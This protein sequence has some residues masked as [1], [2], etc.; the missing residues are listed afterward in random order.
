[1]YKMR[2]MRKDLSCGIIK[3][4]DIGLPEMDVR[5]SGRCIECGHCALFCPESANCLSFLKNDEMVA[6]DDLDMPTASE[7]IEFYKVQEKHK[8]VQKRTFA[9]GCL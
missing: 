3:F 4:G 2:D 6:S 5:L 7:A 8:A 1:M 9:S